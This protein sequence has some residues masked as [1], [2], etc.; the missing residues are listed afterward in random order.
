[1][2]EVKAMV[3]MD[4]VS[5]EYQPYIPDET[6]KSFGLATIA[7]ATVLQHNALRI[8]ECKDGARI[9]NH[10]GY[11]SCVRFIGDLIVIASVEGSN[12]PDLT[13]MPVAEFVEENQHWLEDAAE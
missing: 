12:E 7:E 8:V 3:S 2:T 9:G 6:M 11:P 13:V 4:D 5:P 10:G 1:M